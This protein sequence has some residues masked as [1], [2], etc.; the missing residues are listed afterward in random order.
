M[1]LSRFLSPWVCL[2]IIIQARGM[3]GRQK[4]KASENWDRPNFQFDWID[5]LENGFTYEMDFIE[6]SKKG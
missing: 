4:Y 1:Q 6:K 2:G 3:D 5:K